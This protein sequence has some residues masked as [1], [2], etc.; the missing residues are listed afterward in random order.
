MDNL[1]MEELVNYYINDY[2]IFEATLKRDFYEVTGLLTEEAEGN[3][4]QKIWQSIVNF[5]QKFKESLSKFID[6]FVESID[7]IT[8]FADLVKL[9]KFMGLYGSEYRDKLKDLKFKGYKTFKLPGVTSLK[10]SVSSVNSLTY[11]LSREEMEKRIQKIPDPKKV[12][13]DVHKR[14]WGDK[15]IEYPFR[16]D[17]TTMDKIMQVMQ[18]RVTLVRDIKNVKK[19]FITAIDKKKK[20]A[21]KILKQSKKDFKNNKNN[22]SQV[23]ETDVEPE[24][25]KKEEPDVDP[26]TK[27][28][29]MKEAAD[30]S[31]EIVLQDYKENLA[32]SQTYLKLVSATK[33][34]VSALLT[35]SLK[36]IHKIYRLSAKLYRVG[37][38]YMMKLY[39]K[40]H[41]DMYASMFESEIGYIDDI[42]YINAYVETC[43][44]QSEIGLEWEE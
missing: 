29:G 8:Q 16:E 2:T 34:S 13:E 30:D 23:K 26:N 20:E 28:I 43:L 42:E 15:E 3:F 27:K 41:P 6:S 9:G 1:M 17:E 14:A 33:T 44:Y 7:K 36:E 11:D 12:K 24:K 22:K 19:E 38:M 37:G 4:F 10:Q 5:F 31:D 25:P 18:N 32:K 35:A 40:D 39:R 21:E